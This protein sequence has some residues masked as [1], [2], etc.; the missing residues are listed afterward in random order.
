LILFAFRI[1]FVCSYLIYGCFCGISFIL[2]T[3]LINIYTHFGPKINSLRINNVGIIIMNFSKCFKK[4]IYL[5]FCEIGI[6]EKNTNPRVGSPN[7]AQ[8]GPLARPP[9]SLYGAWAHPGP[10]ASSSPSRPGARC[11]AAAATRSRA[12]TSGLHPST[13]LN[14]RAPLIPGGSGAFNQWPFPLLPL[15][16]LLHN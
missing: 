14:G 2:K 13:C 10:V 4:Y 16:L 11:R 5:Y 12:S 8:P 1:I 9:S 6:K 3:Q 15:P 7:L